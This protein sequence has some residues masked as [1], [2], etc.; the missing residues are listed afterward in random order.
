MIHT[1]ILGSY[2]KSLHFVPRDLY[3]VCVTDMLEK[4]Y[5]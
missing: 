5:V 1:R 3:G 4:V 2:H